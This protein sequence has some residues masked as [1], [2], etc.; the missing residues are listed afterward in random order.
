[1][2]TFKSFV[3]AQ[4]IGWILFITSIIIGNFSIL[5][6]GKHPKFF[7]NCTH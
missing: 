2:V 1:M 6:H 7:N 5:A 4:V 3:A